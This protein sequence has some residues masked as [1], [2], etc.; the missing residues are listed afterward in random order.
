VVA[1]G[2]AEGEEKHVLGVGK[3]PRRTPG[4][5]RAVGRLRTADWI[6]ARYL[7]VIDGSKA[8][9]AAWNVFSVNKWKCSVA[10]FTSGGCEGVSARNCQKD[11]D[12]RMRNAYAMNHYAEA[13]EALQKIFRNWKGSIRALPGAWRRAGETLTVHRLV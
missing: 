7:V 3:E 6:E 8:L 10:R 5:Q 2:I 4:G 9:R 13:K 1:L 11:Y 12:R